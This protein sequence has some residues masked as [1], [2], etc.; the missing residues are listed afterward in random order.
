[1][2]APKAAPDRNVVVIVGM[3]KDVENGS[4]YHSP[5][6]KKGDDSW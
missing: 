3:L 4:V 6:A 1:M 5:E 2:A